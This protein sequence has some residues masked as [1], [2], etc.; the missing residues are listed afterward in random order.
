MP[1]GAKNDDGTRDTKNLSQLRLRER[2]A[3]APPYAAAEGQPRVR[4]GPCAEK[5]LRAELG[6][7]QVEILA[8]VDEDECR[9]N[10]GARGEIPTAEPSRGGQ[11]PWHVA[12][13]W[14]D[15]ASP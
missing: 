9:K 8:Q 4:G 3:Q 6:R 13:D 7:V 11:R 2:G 12:D 14:P 10:P 5:A 15:A 1:D